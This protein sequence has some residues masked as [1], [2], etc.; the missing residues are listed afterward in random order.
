MHIGINALNVK[1]IGGLAHFKNLIEN[2]S[3]NKNIF[4]IT[5]WAS[6]EA[7]NQLKKKHQKINIKKIYTNNFILANIQIFFSYIKSDVKILYSLNGITFTK[8]SI[9]L[10]QNLL[11]F[12]DYEILRHGFSLKTV[13]FFLL[14]VIYKISFFLSKGRIYLNIYNKNYI[15]NKIGVIDKNYKIIPHGITGEFLKKNKNIVSNNNSLHLLYVSNFE[16]Y[17]NH[18]Q[19]LEAYIKYLDSNNKKKISIT[20]VGN[21]IESELKNK[22]IKL[23]RSISNYKNG[24]L[25][26]VNFSKKKKI[27]QLM[28]SA[29][30]ILFASSC[31]S[32]GFPVLEAMAMK[33]ILLCSKTS[34]LKDLSQ[35]KAI[36]FDPLKSNTIYNSFNKFIK[37]KKSKVVY[38][39]SKYNWKA[40]SK[41]TFEA[42][43]ELSSTNKSKNNLLQMIFNNVFNFSF[44]ITYF[45]NYLILNL[46][47][48]NAYI[49]D[50][51][52]FIKNYLYVVSFCILFIYCF[53]A[54]DKSLLLKKFSNNEFI[55]TLNLRLFISALIILLSVIIFNFYLKL[56]FYLVFSSSILAC[57]LWFYEI[58]QVKLEKTKK[59]NLLKKYSIYL[60]LLFII[61]NIL[62]VYGYVNNFLFLVNLLIIVYLLKLIHIKFFILKKF[63][64]LFKLPLIKNFLLLKFYST[65]LSN[66]SNF[67]LRVLI[68]KNFLVKDSANI[69]LGLAIMSLPQTLIVNS[70]G[71]SYIN[72]KRSF[73]KYFYILILFYFI[74]AL[75]FIISEPIIKLLNQ[76][77]YD[78][79]VTLPFFAFTGLIFFLSQLSRQIKLFNID[80]N[81]IF[82]K[83]IIYSVFLIFVVIVIFTINKSL[84]F[85]SLIMLA[86]VSLFIYL[87]K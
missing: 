29:D 6:K 24:D 17:K 86:F 35:N 79:K 66:A 71:P 78:L 2:Y 43:V 62:Y 63:N 87:K 70:F 75:Y 50:Q 60:F 59:Y 83:D 45:I 32:F 25:K 18:L 68:L 52:L 23:K 14:R 28:N 1:S 53:S 74:L 57:I 65:Y 64:Y 37:L 77:N 51:Y 8:N 41:N 12:D 80:A 55:K 82:K 72:S 76:N 33:K 56:D 67:I 58:I 48:L 61:F 9:I 11:P 19:V 85:Y 21:F 34:G 10:Y 69:I 44:R 5:I 38:K 4:K 31:E 46:I 81:V 7:N 27:I 13:K 36:Y 26:I 84:L 3:N 16:I 40:I 39:L 49:Y 20:F 42:I 30:G 15:Q 22:I 73:P 47:F 54:N